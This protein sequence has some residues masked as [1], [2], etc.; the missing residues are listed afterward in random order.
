LQERQVA[1]TVTKGFFA[2]R[3]H[4]LAVAEEKAF[5]GRRKATMETVFGI[6]KHVTWLLAS[7]G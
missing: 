6:T 4:G 5:Y 1:P 3:N 2:R 7:P